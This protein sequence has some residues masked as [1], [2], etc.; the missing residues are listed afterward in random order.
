MSQPTPSDSGTPAAG[1]WKIN[2]ICLGLLALLLLLVFWPGLNYPFL[3]DWDDG[4]FVMFNS[5]LAFTLENFRL[6]AL[7]P[8]QDLYTPLPMYSFM[9]DRALFGLEPLGFRLHNLLLH[10]TAAAFLFL[11]IRQLG[12]RVWLALGAAL[13]W[14]ANPQKVE[15]V[16]WITERKDVLCGA[17]AFASLWF[18]LRSVSRRRVPWIA[19]VLAVLAIFAKPAAIS[20]PGVMIVGLICLRGNRL[21]VREYWRILRLP[22]LLSLG[23]VV[24]S[25]LVTAKTNPGVMETNLLIP[26]HNMFWYPLTALIPYETNPIYPE[27]RGWSELALPAAGGIALLGIYVLAA[28]KLGMPWRRIVCL[29]LIVGGFSVPVLGMLQYTTFHYCDRYNYLVSGAA[30]LA[31]AVPAELLMR[32]LPGAVRYVKGI[33]ALAFMAFWVLTWSYIPRWEYC[34]FLFAYPIEHDPVP[35]V[36]ALESGIYAALRT[37]N[38]ALLSRIAEHMRTNHGEYGIAEQQAADLICFL[39][40]HVALLKQDLPTAFAAYA[41]LISRV[42]QTGAAG[43]LWPRLTLAMLFRDLA[44]ISMHEGNPQRAVRFLDMELK[45]RRKDRLQYDLASAMRAKLLGD[46]AGEARAWKR[47]VELAPGIPEY[48]ERY[49][50]LKQEAAAAGQPA[51]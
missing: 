51:E 3:R 22:V 2:S 31:V 45:V 16:I 12:A 50:R 20:L 24:W 26:L 42:E 4:N 33:L 41:P 43:F 25:S 46:R 11:M 17:F 27:V 13:L 29:L 1:A 44:L 21:S 47:I 37:D 5:N 6:Y 18:F 10:F 23:A 19:G 28:R 15:S 9:L 36:K 35:N 49:E 8:F 30:W 38:L 39:L 7:E 48:Q 34:D 32:R 14:A 40:G